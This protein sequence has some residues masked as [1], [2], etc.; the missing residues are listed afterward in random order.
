MATDVFVYGTLRSG[1]PNWQR[2]LDHEGAALVSAVEHTWPEFGFVSL[3]G[4][5][6]MLTDFEGEKVSVLGEIY[7][8]DSPTLRA[9]DRLEGHPS[10]YLRK[11]IKLASGRIA[12]AYTISAKRF[13]KS[14][15]PVISHGDWIRYAHGAR[16]A[17]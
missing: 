1:E 15:Y 7:T 12:S 5:P 2:Y 14:E 4:F 6:A 16:N 13:Q 11:K 9:L 8:A 17:A 3:G 10:F